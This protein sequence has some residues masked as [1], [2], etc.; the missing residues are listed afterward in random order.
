MRSLADLR[1]ALIQ[2]ALHWEDAGA[3]LAMFEEKIWQAGSGHDLIILPEM[4]TTGFSMQPA[5]VAE[6]M[7]QRTTRWMGQMA[8]QTGAVVLGSFIAREGE[9]FFNRL[10]WA[11]P[12]GNLLTYDKKHLFRMGEENKVY[13]PGSSRLVAEW[14]GWR[15][16]PLVC[17]DL[18]FPVWSRN[19]FNPETGELDYDLLVYVANWPQA[20]S[21]AWQTLLQARAIE[22]HCYCVGLNR[23]GPDGKGIVHGGDSAVCGPKGERLLYMADH[24]ETASHVLSAAALMQHREQFPAWLDGDSFTLG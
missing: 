18:R 12:D 13:T 11:A 3:N 22:N 8:L 6:H 9:R 4:F 15:I 23:I 7:N 5:R 17:Y 1:I 16:C 20:R 2:S 21:I 14:K 10:V 19:R 24:E